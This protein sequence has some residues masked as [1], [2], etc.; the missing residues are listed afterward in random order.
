MNKKILCCIALLAAITTG[1]CQWNADPAVNN[2]IANAPGEEAIP[3]TASSESGTTYIAWFSNESG[4]YNV[5]LQ[6]FDVQGVKQ[7]ADE[8]L[9]VSSHPSMSWLTDWDMTIDQQDCAIL[10]FQDVRNTDN[11]VFA[12]RISP[13]GSFLWGADGIELSNGPAFDVAPK[14][15]VTSSGN[16]VI[17]WQ[18]DNVVIRQKISPDGAKL[19]GASGITMSGSNTYSWP[20]LL[21]VGTDD[22][23]MKYFEDSGPVW[24]P[25]RHVFARRFDASGNPVWAAP[26]VV[27]NAGGISAWTQVFPFINDG[28][29][30]FFIAWHDDRDFNNL[31][32]IFVQHIG[33]SGNALFSSN[34]IEASLFPNRHHFY[35]HLAL[36]E[37]SDDVFVFWNEMDAN[38]NNR[39]I[40]GQKISS[41]G[42]RL[43][44]DNAKA[45]I[46]I[47]PLDI[48]PF[49]S[50][51]SDNEM[52][53]F[54]EE[55]P[56]AS[57]AVIKALA[58]DTAGN[59][60][61]PG[62][63]APVSSLPSSKVHA[64]AGDFMNGQWIL[65]WE[66]DRNGGKDIFAQNLKPDGTLGPVSTLMEMDL[67]ITLFLEGPFNGSVMETHLNSN[68]YIP[69]N[70]PFN[71][72]PW[73]YGGPEQV[74]S[75]P[76]GNVVDWAL[77][78][79]RDASGGPETALPSTVIDRKAVFLLSDGSIAGIDGAALPHFSGHNLNGNLYVAVWHRNHL[80][81]ISN[82]ALTPAKG[83][84]IYDF[85]DNAGK[86]YGGYLAQKEINGAMA[87]IAGDGNYDGGVN[88]LDKVDVWVVEAGLSGYFQGDF[89]LNG[90]VDNS[91]KLDN[92][93]PNAGNSTQVSFNALNNPPVAHIS[94]TPP[95]GAPDTVFMFDA[96]QSTDPEN[97]AS[98]LRV[99][100]DFDGN[101]IWD[102]GWRLD[103]SASHQYAQPGDYP[104]VL[105]VIDTEGLIDHDT[106][107]IIVAI[108]AD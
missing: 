59:F 2:L 78:E 92:W 35:A 64:V 63:K 20:Q 52:V 46:E 76:N 16:A 66:D 88:N 38:Q 32:G 13:G 4:N 5:R 15:C 84:Y 85:T 77:L 19:W 95:S 8:G 45:F 101:G 79:L 25:T 33:P 93:A 37:G 11:D 40:Y 23:I 36:P 12:Y 10:T 29:D 104:A 62:E 67:D 60:V 49:A 102:T 39:G 7:W 43:W 44:G 3:K 28:N 103:K 24:A 9:L 14:V 18:A 34:G 107:I 75:I 69:L 106:I 96:S 27:S 108:Q 50:S 55:N 65:S 82:D 105:Q 56:S 72:A 81:I 94:V 31:S 58:V 80:G 100:W 61:W 51:Q 47:S 22:V 1:T 21:P 98:A 99:R 30:G 87:M 97:P 68:G 6:K 57:S 41:Q 26:A 73:H 74:A 89:S 42:N 54:Y 17:A 48:Y 91:D 53:V 71:V 86:A 83:L 70:Q 90:S